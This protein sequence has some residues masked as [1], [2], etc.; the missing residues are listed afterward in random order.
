MGR[1]AFG[2]TSAPNASALVDIVSTTAGLGLPSMT[3]AQVNAISSPRDGLIVYDS[4]TDTV[5]LRSNSAWVELYTTNNITQRSINAQTGTSYTLVLSDAGKLITLNNASAITLTIPTNASVAFP[6]GTVI[7][8]TQFGAGQ[9]TVGG[10]GVTIN[11]AD[12]DKKLRVRY[13][14]ASLIK[15]DTDTWLLVGD[16]SS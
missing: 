8:I 6:I 2:T 12:G 15:T 10:S 16:I 4:D 11:S 1:T 9:V 14:S 3:T 7:D 5:K 13:S